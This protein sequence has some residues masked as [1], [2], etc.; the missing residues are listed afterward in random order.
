[1]I[2]DMDKSYYPELLG[3]MLVLNAPTAFYA[4]WSF[5]SAFLDPR[6]RSKIIVCRD[7]GL[8]EWVKIMG[9]LDRVPVEYGG[10]LVVHP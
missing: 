1:M 7:N 10:T 8:D 3:T 9:S 4:V 2:S 6:T 5:V